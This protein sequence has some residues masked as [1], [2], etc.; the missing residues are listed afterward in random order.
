L[1]AII[2]AIN[3]QRPVDSIKLSDGSWNITS[4]NDTRNPVRQALEG[5]YY[6]PINYNILVN[7]N[8]A[9]TI[10]PDLTLK[11]T[12]GLSYNINSA[13]Q[14]QNQ[15]AW[16]N[17]TVTGPNSSTMSNFIDRE[18]LQQLDLT[19]SKNIRKHHFDMIVGGQ[20]N[21]HNYNSTT[22]SRGNF[23]NNSSNSMQLGDPSSQTNSSSQYKW[24][25]EGLFGRLN[26]DFDRKYMVE[27][28]FREDVSS[29]LNPATNRDFFPSA[30]AGWRISQENFWGKIKHMLPEFKVRASYGTLGNANVATST[31][32]NNAMF[33]SYNSIIGN[34]YSSG[35]GY[36]LASVFDGTIY[37]GFSLV[38]N[39][40]NKLRWER[41]TMAD[42]A[43]DGTIFSPRLT[44]TIDYF[45][46]TTNSMLLQ[47]PVSDVNGVTSQVGV[48]ASPQYPANLGSMYNRG[49]EVS[50]G[51]SMQN[52]SGFSYSMNAN[53]TYITSK[54]TNLG[55]LNLASTNS[56]AVGFPLSAYF[57]YVNDGYLTKDEFVAQKSNDPILKGQKWGDQKIK[58]L[59]NDSKIT[60]DDRMMID[61]S[62]VP[63][64]LFGF[65]F[66]FTYKGF[67]VAGMLQGAMNYYKYLGASVGYGFNSGYSITNWSIDNSYNPLIDPN[68]YNTRLP[69]VSISNTI[70]NTYNS[71]LFLFNSSYV[72]LKNFQIYYDLPI[73]ASKKMGMKNAR[74]YVS[75]QNLL[76]FSKLPKALGIDP[77]INS[78]TAGYPLV[79]IYTTGLNISF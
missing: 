15:L 61:K 13:S 19:Y 62:R 45:N 28:N 46:K 2:S 12:F 48:G 30:A 6:N 49:L 72:R 10:I 43:I 71:T 40:N 63:K 69:R 20:Q 75:G 14:F 25:L 70:N 65:N 36:N 22:L 16:Y 64:H 41:T 60:A 52:N 27:L 47:Y 38:Q 66:D 42:I 68:S 55:G 35:L 79:A 5:G 31:G 3:R 51:Y 26:Y 24:I 57:L 17:G 54:I 50:F 59:T 21:I 9:Y 73:S 11:Y 4:T 8:T 74:I 56:L 53:Y 67:G 29:R 34:V 77:E 76:T 18:N 7:F 37:N 58:D 39:P 23:I 44:Y 1:G 32:N 78:A 33:Y